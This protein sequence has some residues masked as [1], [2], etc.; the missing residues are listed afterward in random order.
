MR[1]IPLARST[2]VVVVSPRSVGDK[3]AMRLRILPLLAALSCANDRL[4]SEH[5]ERHRHER[6]YAAG[7]ARG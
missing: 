1:T 7:C 2:D 6:N 4:G 5:K 3:N